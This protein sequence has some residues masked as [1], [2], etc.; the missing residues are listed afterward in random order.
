MENRRLVF[1]ELGLRPIE[2]GFFPNLNRQNP[3]AI[4]ASF[5]FVTSGKI[6]TRTSFSERGRTFRLFDE[7]IRLVAAWIAIAHAENFS[8][9]AQFKMNQIGCDRHETILRIANRD[10]DDTHVPAV[11]IDDCA[12]GPCAIVAGSPVVSTFVSAASLP[13]LKPFALKHA[14]SIFYFPFQLGIFFHGL[15]SDILAVQKQFDFLAIAQGANVNFLAF[16]ARPV[17]MRKQMQNNVRR[18]PRLVI[19]KIIFRKTAGV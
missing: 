7:L 10:R 3:V 13:S 12:V 2:G 11:G 18:P 4:L 8:G 15:A 16:F 17:P 1:L 9:A 6:I 14:G 5:E 19:P